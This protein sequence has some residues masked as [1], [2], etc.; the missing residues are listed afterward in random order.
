MEVSP[1]G[2]VYGVYTGYTEGAW[3][4]YGGYMG[5]M[6][7]MGYG[8]RRPHGPL[9]EDDDPATADRLVHSA[10]HIPH[11][12]HMFFFRARTLNL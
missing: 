9:G 10:S 7:C 5:Y 3:R 2:G 6:G 12:P 11:I 8:T 1:R 4:V